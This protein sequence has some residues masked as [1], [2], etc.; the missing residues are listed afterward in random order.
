MDRASSGVRPY[1]IIW[2]NTVFMPA[3]KDLDGKRNA[4]KD[5]NGNILCEEKY[6]G[7][8]SPEIAG[9]HHSQ[10]VKGFYLGKFVYELDVKGQ[11]SNVAKNYNLSFD[12]VN[13]TCCEFRK[14]AQIK[15]EII[16]TINDQLTK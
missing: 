7:L 15:Q 14:E 12:T 6:V 5:K 9:G 13:C 8:K 10:P 4:D 16:D 2:H 11:Y 1:I 3:F